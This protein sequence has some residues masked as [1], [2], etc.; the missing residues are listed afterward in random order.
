MAC[1]QGAGR[2]AFICTAAIMYQL[3]LKNASRGVRRSGAKDSVPG[4]GGSIESKPHHSSF[5]HPSGKSAF[6]PPHGP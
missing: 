5:I 2:C 3:T 6:F 4:H 1:W